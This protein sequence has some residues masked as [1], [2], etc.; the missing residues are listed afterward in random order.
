MLKIHRDLHLTG[1][2]DRSVKE[3]FSLILYFGGF[4]ACVAFV[5]LCLLWLFIGH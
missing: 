2:P 1:N 4:V 3:G 5:L